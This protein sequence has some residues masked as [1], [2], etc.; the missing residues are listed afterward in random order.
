MR[1]DAFLPFWCWC[2]F[3]PFFFLF[4]LQKNTKNTKNTKKTRKKREEKKGRK[5]KGGK[6]REKNRLNLKVC[7]RT[8]SCFSR[9]TIF[10]FS[11]R[12]FSMPC[13]EDS[14]LQSRRGEEGFKFN[15]F[16]PPPFSSFSLQTLMGL[17]SHFLN[18]LISKTKPQRLAA[19]SCLK[20]NEKKKFFSLFLSFFRKNKRALFLTLFL[21]VYFAL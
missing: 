19:P 15:S 1:L 7:K 12:I 6:K 13:M 2:F 4:F 14:L 10:P 5:K 21:V 3:P 20:D 18:L 11:R 9:R 8:I 16:C 17:F